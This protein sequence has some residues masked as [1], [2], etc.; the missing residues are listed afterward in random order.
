MAGAEWARRDGE[1]PSTVDAASGI[2]SDAAPARIDPEALT[3]LSENNCFRSE[4][5]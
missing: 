4:N 1:W 2:P 3:T 5:K